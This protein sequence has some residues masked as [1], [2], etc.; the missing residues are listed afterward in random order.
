LTKVLR[1]IG[2]VCVLV[3]ALAG[4][5]NGQAAVA[6]APEPRFA[7][8]PWGT[9]AAG[10]E[11]A[12]TALG[13]KLQKKHDEGDAM[14]EGRLFDQDA[15]VLTMMSAKG[16]VKVEVGL[17]TPDDVAVGVYRNLVSTLTSKY[18]KP[19]ESVETYEA[20]YAK[21]DG[22]ETLAIQSGK[23]TLK[24][25][26]LPQT[27]PSA[28]LVTVTDKLLVRLVYESDDWAAESGRRTKKAKS[29]F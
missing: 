14:Y 28:L 18:G 24:T 21:G 16:L 19:D 8:I 20:P 13:M 2:S 3:M 25:V 12:I 17:G 26:W 5:A 27:A 4:V 6:K 29:V 9:S 7:D 11:K 10:V 15:F 23:A 1:V 22:F